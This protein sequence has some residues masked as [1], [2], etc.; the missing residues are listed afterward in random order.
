M[1]L[2]IIYVCTNMKTQQ[3]RIYDKFLIFDCVNVDVYYICTR[4]KGND[5]E[6]A[7]GKESSFSV[8]GNCT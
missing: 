2:H 6:Y 4:M 3:K 7:A 1:F 5:N 8:Q